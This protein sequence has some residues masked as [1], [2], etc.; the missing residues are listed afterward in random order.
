MGLDMYLTKRTYVK[1]WEHTPKER[2][3][4]ITITGEGGKH[5]KPNRVTEISEE[6]MYW[7]K[8]NQIHNWIVNN[9]DDFEDDGRPCILSLDHLTRLR[10][11]CAMVL[12]D[13]DLAPKLLPTQSGF[14]WGGTEYDE[15]YFNQV[16]DTFKYLNDI[17]LELNAADSCFIEYRASW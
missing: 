5:I 16:L 11:V 17:I 15:W 7:R 12:E 1:Q 10:D 3:V 13:D 9:V 6:L 2:K 8:A 4:N 14:F